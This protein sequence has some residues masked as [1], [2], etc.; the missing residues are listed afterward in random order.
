MKM[1]Y[2]WRC[3]IDVPMLD[4]DEFAIVSQLYSESLHATICVAT[5]RSARCRSSRPR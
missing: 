2:C 1:L 5:R 4:E 3:K